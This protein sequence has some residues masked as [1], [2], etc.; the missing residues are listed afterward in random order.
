MQVR[1]HP[2]R[3]WLIAVAV[4]FACAACQPAGAASSSPAAVMTHDAGNVECPTGKPAHAGLQN[5]GAYIGTWD[6]NHQR[7]PKSSGSYLIGIVTG[8]L[9]VR[10]NGDDYVVSETMRPLFH[11]PEG[12]AVRIAL[13]DLPDD[14]EKVYDHLHSGCRVLQYKSSKLAHQ[15]GADDGDGHVDIVFTSDGATYTGVVKTILLDLWD[16]LGGDTRAC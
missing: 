11:S 9:D 7:D 14:S 13:T 6:S 10:C 12:Q 1:V 3:P 5:F 16:K 8:S 4:I 15:L 2:R